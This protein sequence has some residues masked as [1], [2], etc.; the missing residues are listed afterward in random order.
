MSHK[1]KWFEKIYKKQGLFV[2]IIKTLA[3][4]LEARVNTKTYY[5]SI[6]VCLRVAQRY[7]HLELL[8]LENVLV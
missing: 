6:F 3:E 1:I 5:E 8:V 7:D 2:E 4:V